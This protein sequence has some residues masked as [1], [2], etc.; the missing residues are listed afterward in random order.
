M[1]S[2]EQNSKR[3]VTLQGWQ[4]ETENER[5]MWTKKSSSESKFH[6][7]RGSWLKWTH[8]ITKPFSFRVPCL[9]TEFVRINVKFYYF[10]AKFRAKKLLYIKSAKISQLAFFRQDPKCPRL[11]GLFSSSWLKAQ[12]GKAS[13]PSLALVY[14]TTRRGGT[15]FS[16]SLSLL[17]LI[18]GNEMLFKHSRPECQILSRFF[19]FLQF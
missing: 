3:Q 13:F 14:S 5:C 9:L 10:G 18:K 7:Q 19:L 6:H 4:K 15:F 1:L 2:F 11:L 17:A 12:R 8:C 16:F